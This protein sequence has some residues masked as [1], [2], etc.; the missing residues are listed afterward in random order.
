MSNFYYKMSHVSYSLLYPTRLYVKYN[1]VI[2]VYS[3]KIYKLRAGE[4][5]YY[6]S[7]FK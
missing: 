1:F 2:D 6:P 3:N 4:L 7:E 5:A